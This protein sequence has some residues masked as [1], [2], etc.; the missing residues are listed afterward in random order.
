VAFAALAAS[1]VF[2]LGSP[3][4]D[5]FFISDG[6]YASLLRRRMLVWQQC[7]PV[8]IFFSVNR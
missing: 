7:V 1:M 4:R 6:F 3:A 5:C 2:S 8:C